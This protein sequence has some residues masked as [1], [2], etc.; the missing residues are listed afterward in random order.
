M[1]TITHPASATSAPASPTVWTPALWAAAVLASAGL[2]VTVNNVDNITHWM[3][4]EEPVTSWWSTTRNNP[5]NALTGGFHHFSNL[6][7]S[8]V[9]TGQLLK[10]TYS[11]HYGHQ[12]TVLN[13]TGTLHAFSAAVVASSWAG[14]H[15]GGTSTAIAR[16]TPSPSVAAPATHGTPVA[17]LSSATGVTLT[18]AGST[19]GWW[20]K[21]LTILS[22]L[23]TPT[24][25][26]GELTQPT[27][28]SSIPG[29]GA[30]DT[31]VT[32]LHDLS[33]W[34]RVGIF[35]GGA[36]LTLV[37]IFLLAQSSKGVR[38]VET[39]AATA[40]ALA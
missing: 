39:S 26:F 18:A 40:A 6:G 3:P 34:R 8:A 13:Q 27:I 7:Q 4:A 31:F 28:A 17:D 12:W 1:A 23:P 32:E 2:P 38:N 9:A 20:T 33:F 16:T 29:L 10:S 5:L 15:Y 22:H 36:V 24:N 37:G 30:L 19:T 35:A 21:A 14:G 11:G 25:P